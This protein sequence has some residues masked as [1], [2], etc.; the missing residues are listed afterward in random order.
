M[1]S[2]ARCLRSLSLAP[3][4]GSGK[5]GSGAG[6]SVAANPGRSGRHKGGARLLMSG[7][8]GTKVDDGDAGQDQR[9]SGDQRKSNLLAR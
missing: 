4:P 1:T 7:G 2:R 9:P 5:A 3:C 6:F 8:P